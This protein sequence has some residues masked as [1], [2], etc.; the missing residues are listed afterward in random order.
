MIVCSLVH[1]EAIPVSYIINVFIYL[2]IYFYTGPILIAV[3]KT[4]MVILF[5]HAIIIIII[6]IIKS[7]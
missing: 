5:K 4:E 7:P 3:F 2:F 1:K 6:I